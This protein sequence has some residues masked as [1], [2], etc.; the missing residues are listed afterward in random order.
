MS[1]VKTFRITGEIKK[2][3]GNINFSKEMKGLRKEQVV[4]RLY[5]ELGSKHKA[6]RFEITFTKIAE[7]KPA[8]EKATKTRK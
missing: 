4:E 3:T 1:E 6:K 8:P 7:E 5:A 2:P